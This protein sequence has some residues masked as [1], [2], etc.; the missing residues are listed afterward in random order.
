MLINKKNP[1]DEDF[2]KNF[3][4]LNIS[5]EKLQKYILIELEKSLTPTGTDEK[6]IAETI[7]IEHILPKNP[8]ESWAT[9]FDLENKEYKDYVNR[10]GNLTLLSGKINPK[11]GNK[12]F[13]E[14]VNADDG[15]RI[16]DVRLTKQ[17]VTDYFPKYIKWDKNTIEQRQIGLA[18]MAKKIWEI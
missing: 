14:K 5:K 3:I 17:L 15:Y 1:S 4:K 16:S 10:I 9:V 7:T 12:L 8:D 13:E 6:V 11:L 2:E 18:Q